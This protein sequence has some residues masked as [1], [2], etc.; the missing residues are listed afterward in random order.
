MAAAGI[1]FSAPAHCG[2]IPTVDAGS[3]AQQVLAY[4]QR[5]RAY[6]VQLRQAGL[7]TRQLTTL[8]RQFDQTLREYDDYLQQVKG[9]HR[10]ISR[11]DWNELF[12]TLRRRY[13][14]SAYAR[15]VT[16]NQVGKAGRAT[17]DRQ[18]GALYAVPKPVA[19][20]L[21]QVDSAGLDT[22][23][24]VAQAERQRARYEAYRDQLEF[25]R[26]SSRELSERHRRVGRTKQNF[27][28]GD[29]SDLN[30][31]QTAVTSNFHIIDELQALNKLQHQRLLHAN[32]EFMQ[33]LSGIEA[34]RQAELARAQRLAE[35]PKTAGSFHWGALETGL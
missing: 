33:T 18:V 34:A 15:V 32:H 28:L 7:D 24:W 10:R 3:I 2:G 5:L 13:G 35:Q 23:P 27:D 21:R 17:I 26:D 25:A 12:Q 14:I 8:N 11:R 4:Q 19:E 9:L 16:G 30:A 1:A 20:A 6:E 22:D 29:K 31:L